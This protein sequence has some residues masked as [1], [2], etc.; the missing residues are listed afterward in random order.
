MKK[1][2]HVMQTNYR[3]QNKSRNKYCDLSRLKQAWSLR[4][5][6]FR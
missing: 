6:R 4:N 2:N 5:K 1:S 3:F